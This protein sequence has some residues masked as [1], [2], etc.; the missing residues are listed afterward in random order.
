MSAPTTDL[1]VGMGHTEYHPVPGHDVE[2]GLRAIY[3]GAKHGWK[4]GVRV[5]E[6]RVPAVKDD[7]RQIGSE[8]V[9]ADEA[10]AREAANAKWMDL[11]VGDWRRTA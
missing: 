1:R 5:L 3:Q 10:E 11:K 6:V 9:Y 7:W 4:F 8:V 2:V